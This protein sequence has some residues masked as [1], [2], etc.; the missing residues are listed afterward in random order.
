M[1]EAND[2]YRV[3]GSPSL[4]ING[5]SPSAKRDAQSL[6]TLICSAF[7]EQPTECSEQLS[8]APPSPGFGFE[9][10]GSNTGGCGG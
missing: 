10:T 8:T 3:Q 7:N 1:R 2:E 4:V 9:G 6:L 5:V